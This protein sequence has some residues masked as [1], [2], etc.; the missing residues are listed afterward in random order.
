[1][2]YRDQLK[3]VPKKIDLNPRFNK[4]VAKYSN[5]VEGWVIVDTTLNKRVT[6]E[7]IKSPAVAKVAATLHS[8]RAW[9]AK[10]MS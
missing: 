8:I 4:F 5:K 3:D 2:I 9:N 10:N 7:V 1:M 6:P